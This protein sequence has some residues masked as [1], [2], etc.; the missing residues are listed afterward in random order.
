MTSFEALLEIDKIMPP[1]AVNPQAFGCDGQGVMVGYY[2]RAGVHC[3]AQTYEVALL[4]LK[5]L[6]LE[7]SSL[8]V[9]RRS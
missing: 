9:D 5:V 4:K 1:S 2:N 6:T 7:T 3:K 8:Q